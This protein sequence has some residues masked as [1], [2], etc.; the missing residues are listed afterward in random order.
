MRE[1]FVRG[2][3]SHSMNIRQQNWQLAENKEFDVVIIGGGINGATIYNRLCSRGYKVLLV[4]KGD[5]SCGTSQASAMMIWGGLLYLKNLDF[6]SVFRFSKDRDDLIK[7]HEKEIDPKFFRYIPSCEWGRNKC[8]VYLA[9]YLYWILG[10]FRRQRPSFQKIYQ[11]LKFLCQKK[12]EGSFIYQEGF[13]KDS[14]SR[15]VLNWILTHQTDDSFALNYCLLDEAVY[16]AKDKKWA[17]NVSDT[18]QNSGNSI[19]A[20]IIVNCAGVWADSVNEQFGIQTEYRHVFSKGVFIGLKRPETHDVPLI[21]EMG[22]HGDTLT[23]IP[24]GPISL[25]GPTETMED[26]I[27]KGFSI[28]PRDIHFLQYHAL[29]NLESSLAESEIISLRCGIRPLAVDKGF[30]ADCYPLDISRYHKIAADMNRPWITVYGGKISGCVSMAEE[31][32]QKIARQVQPSLENL[33]GGIMPQC[34]KNMVSFPGL[35]E[36]FPSIGWCVQNEFCCSFEDYLRR[37]TNIS[38]WLPREGLGFQNEN[39][40]HLR[41]LAQHLPDADGKTPDS[42]VE[43]YVATVKERF[44]RLIAQI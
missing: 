18:L 34:D 14:D 19:T 3:A 13:L 29:K 23:F 12:A 25:W 26:S 10:N 27:E 9:L 42:Y 38:Q 24:W 11:E 7:R 30:K 41:S 28:T 6:L 37:R 22:E 20:K 2:Y 4:D 21:F 35:Q 33:T 43:E 5:F 15:F 44:D 8:L 1:K 17:I 16:S 31:V 36:K 32:A 40:E 39:K